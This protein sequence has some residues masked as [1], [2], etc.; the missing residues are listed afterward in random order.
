MFELDFVKRGYSIKEL[1]RRNKRRL[2]KI[3]SYSMKGIRQRKNYTKYGKKSYH[4]IKEGLEQYAHENEINKI[5]RKY[6]ENLKMQDN[7]IIKRGDI[8]Y[9]SLEEVGEGSE[10]AGRRP[11]I[12]VQ[13]DTGNKYSST[14]IV[15]F[16]TSK[17]KTVLPTHVDLVCG[18]D[19]KLLQKSD[20]SKNIALCEQVRTISKSRIIHKLGTV[21]PTTMK[22]IDKALLISQ[23]IDIDELVK[24]YKYKY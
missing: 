14:T 15:V 11:A 21:T 5:Q 20:Y 19:Y 12:V 23:G 3:S 6:C 8:V 7:N 9:C 22:K 18:R 1:N 16:L 13:N 2:L 24:E 17:N 4:N 10:Q